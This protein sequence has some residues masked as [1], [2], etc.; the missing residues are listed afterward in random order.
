M[1]YDYDWPWMGETQDLIYQ[2]E[3]T[4]EQL[5]KR[6]AEIAALTSRREYLD[7]EVAAYARRA[8]HAERAL[9]LSG[10]SGEEIMRRWTSGEIPE[11]AQYREVWDEEM[12][13]KEKLR[14]R[15]AEL[16][17]LSSAAVEELERLSADFD[18]YREYTTAGFKTLYHERRYGPAAGAPGTE[19]LIDDTT[20]PGAYRVVAYP[21][22][23]A[24]E[25]RWDRAKFEEQY[26]EEY[27]DKMFRTFTST[28]YGKHVGTEAVSPVAT[29]GSAEGTLVTSPI[30]QQLTHHMRE[31]R[32]IHG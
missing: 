22:P 29:G 28:G 11:V 8:R 13:E 4:T 24:E 9:G 23:P 3:R 32:K 26:G 6:D 30:R 10:L 21:L 17:D 16:E 12:D 14:E 5:K 25:I 27:T 19:K 18:H 15:V 20:K 31:M 1:G 2:L 7:S